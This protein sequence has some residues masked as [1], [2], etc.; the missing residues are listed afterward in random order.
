MAKRDK[1]GQMTAADSLRELIGNEENR[2]QVRRVFGLDVDPG[3]PP[4]L[5]SPLD[6]IEEARKGTLN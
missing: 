3:L 4:T 6:A 2:R 1:A 5:A